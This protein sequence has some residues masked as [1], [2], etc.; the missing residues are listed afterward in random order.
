MLEVEGGSLASCMRILRHEAGHAIDTAYQLH[1]RKAWRERFGSFAE[2]YP[3]FY[4]PRPY[5]RNFVVHLDMWYAQAHPAED[6][7]ETFAVWLRRGSHWRTRYK[8]WGA[9]KKLKYVDEL[10]KEIAG[11]PPVLRTRE[12]LEP[13]R[14]LRTTLRE[15]YRKKKAYYSREFPEFYDRDLRRLF[16]DQKKHRERP[17]AASFLRAIR[18]DIRKQV[19]RWTGESQYTIDQVLRDMT[20]RATQLKLRMYHSPAQT[21]LDVMLLVT[22]QTMNYLHGGHHRVAL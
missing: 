3:K 6:F 4:Q 9:L 21:K 19:A 15:H 5:S 2:P 20:A 13:L 16:S 11:T 18:P 8:G 10:M 1:R 22:V 7:A 17:T 12:Q 14:E